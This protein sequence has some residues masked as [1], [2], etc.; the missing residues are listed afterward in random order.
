M[1]TI[2]IDVYFLLNFT[3]DLLSVYFASRLSKVCIKNVNMILISL[4]GALYSVCL[5]LISAG[6]IIDLLM[7]LA[8][9]VLVIL[10][11]G[12]GIALVRRIKLLICYIVLMALI[13]GVVHFLYSVLSKYFAYQ[14]T[15][16]PQNRKLLIL[17]ILIIIAFSVIKLISVVFSKTKVERNVKIA[18]SLMGKRVECDALV[19][20]GNLLHDPIDSTP[21][22]LIAQCLADKIMPGG[23]PQDINSI[24]A[25]LASRVRIIPVMKGVERKIYIGFLP[26]SVEVKMK[27]EWERV[28]LI[29]V[30]DRDARDFGGYFALAPASL[31]EV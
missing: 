6:G 17:S 31:L 26:D 11:I 12:R 30:V 19:D 21:V 5:V 27:K 24:P 28:K 14:P 10:F 18:I 3:V 29:F 16:Q 7:L 4:I 23:V 15:S 8:S 22:M 13:G 1:K 9:L 25:H 2:Y 20:T